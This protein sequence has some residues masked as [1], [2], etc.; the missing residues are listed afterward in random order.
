MNN[1]F[2]R[3]MTRWLKSHPV[4]NLTAMC[5]AVQMDDGDETA[6]AL[7]A[8]R[9]P[10]AIYNDVDDDCMFPR[11]NP[12]T[13]PALGLVAQTAVPTPMR[14]FRGQLDYDAVE[15]GMSYMERDTP[16]L[17]A[18]G[19]GDYV[20][21]AATDS[22]LAFIEP[23]NANVQIPGDVL[24]NPN[25]DTWR[26][27][28]GFGKKGSVEVL[29]ITNVEQFRIRLGVHGVTMFGALIVTC[30]LRRLT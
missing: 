13:V 22:L 21:Q 15:I 4:Y 23:K 19:R 11:H 7:N 3:I 9:L 26:S 8:T 27:L 1:R 16:E 18:K 29:D 24:P 30:K 12:T 25:S 6:L 2:T 28:G 20:L 5:A 14:R 10:C 17:A